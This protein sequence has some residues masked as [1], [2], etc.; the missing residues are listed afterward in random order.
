MAAPTSNSILR[1]S[2]LSE[3][4]LPSRKRGPSKGGRWRL[5]EVDESGQD[6]RQGLRLPVRALRA[7]DEGGLAVLQPEPGIE[8]V[9]GAFAGRQRVRAALG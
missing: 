9:E 4:V 6:H 1:L 2:R 3:N 8:R 5:A 7:V